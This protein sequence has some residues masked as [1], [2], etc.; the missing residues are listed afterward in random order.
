MI[1]FPERLKSARKMRGWSLEDLAQNL[2]EIKLSVQALSKY[3]T[4][5]LLIPEETLY[6]LAR[7]LGVKPDYFYRSI[8]VETSKVSFRKLEEF[9]QKMQD[10][11]VQQTRDFI[12]RYLEL[13]LLLGIDSKFN[14][15]KFSGRKVNSLEE[16]EE[17][18]LYI[19]K[20]WKLGDG[21]LHNVVEIL[22]DNH[23]KVFELPEEDGFQGMST[24][25]NKTIPI[26]VLNNHSSISNTRKRFTALHELGHI[27]MNLEHLPEKMQEDYCHYFAGALLISKERLVEEMGS[28]HRTKI[29]LSELGQ[30]KK[31]FGISISALVFRLYHCGI[32]SKTFCYEMLNEMRRM[33]I[34]KSE[35]REFDYTGEEKSNRFIQLLMRGI[36]MEL[37]SLSKAAALNN[38]K[39][40]DFRKQLL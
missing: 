21:P 28:P 24:I 33:D 36:S 3:E 16:V 6:H 10:K 19:R 39:L 7:A 13:E 26:V 37:I 32:I 15:R 12:E 25:V 40:A 20:E 5:Q 2:R 30:I 35:P 11:V 17:T 27:V 38:Q 18:A 31:Q 9:P 14:A 23:V 34:F 22:E 29:M 8:S 1:H 4:G